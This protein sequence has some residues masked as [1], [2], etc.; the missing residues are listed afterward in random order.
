MQASV[1]SGG[2]QRPSPMNLAF[3]APQAASNSTSTGSAQ[4]AKGPRPADVEAQQSP[5]SKPHPSLF[6]AAS[7]TPSPRRPNALV[8]AAGHVGALHSTAVGSSH[9]IRV[10]PLAARGPW[11]SVRQPRTHSQSRLSMRYHAFSAHDGK[12]AAAPSVSTL[13]Q[14]LGRQFWRTR[15][16]HVAGKT[17]ARI[18][19]SARTH[20]SAR[21]AGE[22]TP[23]TPTSVVV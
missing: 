6:S 23:P 16:S 19:S 20:P 18:H 21:T 12:I 17:L 7:Q 10:M 13:T 9:H 1:F 4:V 14:G 5:K 8:C 22:A 3:E 2:S 11:G 15:A